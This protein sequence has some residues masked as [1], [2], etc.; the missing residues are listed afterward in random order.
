MFLTLP[1][2]LLKHVISSS[3]TCGKSP[4]FIYPTKDKTRIIVS[5]NPLIGIPSEPIGTNH[6]LC[7]N[8]KKVKNRNYRRVKILHDFT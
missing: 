2:V 8:T 5:K 6:L 4:M 7:F 1:L 3:A